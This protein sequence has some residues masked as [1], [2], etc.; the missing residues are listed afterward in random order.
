MSFVAEKKYIIKFPQK[1]LN[2][3]EN[4]RKIEI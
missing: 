4:D 3:R 1:K 2:D